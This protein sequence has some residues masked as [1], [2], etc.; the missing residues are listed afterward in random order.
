MQIR[1]G[2]PPGWSRLAGLGVEPSRG[3]RCGWL[4]W[5]SI[6][7]AITGSNLP[8]LRHNDLTSLEERS[9]RPRQCRQPTWAFPLE[10]K[11]L[12]TLCS[13]ACPFRSAPYRSMAVPSSLPSSN[14]PVNS[15][16]SICSFCLPVLPNSTCTLTIWRK[17]APRTECSRSGLTSATSSRRQWITS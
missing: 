12:G 2:K 10:E 15:A 9:H 16:A 6:V 1:K 5:I 17:L 8:S 11:V 7:A 4:G 14:W 13:T 3:A